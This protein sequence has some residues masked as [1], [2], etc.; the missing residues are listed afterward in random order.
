MT[1]LARPAAASRPRAQTRERP[2]LRALDR[3]A[4]TPI[5][6]TSDR[7]V[8]A[9]VGGG[10]LF[11][12]VLAGNVAVHAETTQGQFELER[13]EATARE[14]QARY[15]RLRL[16]VA[17][18]EAPKRIVSRARQLGMVEPGRVTYLTPTAATSA[19]DPAARSPR[20]PSPGGEAARSWAQVKP[21][22]ARQR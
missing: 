7:R 18:L 4:G 11:A 1:A 8:V 20:A 19:E 10:L 17:Q 3:P 13:L 14:R 15:Q 6:E 21:H 5:R 12:A 2:A 16:E 9:V 22:L